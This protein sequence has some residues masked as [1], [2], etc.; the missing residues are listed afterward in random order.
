MAATADDTFDPVVAGQGAQRLAWSEIPAD[1]RAALEAQLGAPVPKASARIRVAADTRRWP[2]DICQ[3][4]RA[5]PVPVI[6]T[7]S[8]R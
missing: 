3:G 4:A 2:P 6:R 7:R 5:F 1:V 8:R